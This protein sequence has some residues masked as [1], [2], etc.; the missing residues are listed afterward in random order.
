MVPQR[1]QG[2]IT[3]DRGGQVWVRTCNINSCAGQWQAVAAAGWQPVAS[4]IRCYATQT[5]NLTTKPKLTTGSSKHAQTPLA[6][7][8]TGR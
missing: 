3:Y 5:S 4:S 2:G 6:T 7:D 8:L 1:Q